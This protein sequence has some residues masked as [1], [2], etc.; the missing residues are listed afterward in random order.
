M[1]KNEI[2][3]DESRL[4]IMDT[5]QP[6]QSPP[7]TEQTMLSTSYNLLYGLL[8]SFFLPYLGFHAAHF[9]SANIYAYVCANPTFYGYVMSL[10]ST[11]SPVCAS[12]LNVMVQTS[13][14]VTGVIF[15]SATSLIALLG[16]CYTGK[17]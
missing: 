11:G 16:S 2:A 12:I 1:K 8:V 13:Y 15:A 6:I 17:K 4:F 7:V 5:E 14:G 10:I 3:T 9:V